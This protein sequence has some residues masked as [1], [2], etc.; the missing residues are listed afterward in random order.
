MEDLTASHWDDVLSPSS[1]PFGTNLALENGFQD[2][3]PLQGDDNSEGHGHE[4]KEQEQEQEEEEEEVDSVGHGYGTEISNTTSKFNNLGFNGVNEAEAAQ[5]SELAKEERKEHTSN[6]IS[7]LT[8]G[9]DIAEAIAPSS[10]APKNASD[11]LFKDST[12]PI[13]IASST[14]TNPLIKDV[15]GNGVGKSKLFARSR[16]FNSKTV[17]SNLSSNKNDVKSI[18]NNNNNNNNNNINSSNPLGPLGGEIT[19]EE[20]ELGKNSRDELFKE[21]ESPLYKIP[22]EEEKKSEDLKPIIPR[23][24]TNSTETVPLSGSS[25]EITVGD[26]MK[27]GDITTAHIVYTIHVKN[28]TPIDNVASSTSGI[29]F[30]GSE[31]VSRRYRDFRWLYHQLQNNHLGIIIPPPPT[32]QTYIGRFNENFIENRRLSLEKMLTKIS[33]LPTICNDPDFI[34]FLTST[35]FINESKERERLSGLEIG[36]DEENTSAD[37]NSSVLLDNELVVSAST[38]GFMNSLFSMSNKVN[39]PNDL[40]KDKK[41]YI[42]NLEF[43][44]RNFYKSLELIGGQRGEIITLV[45]EISLLTEELSSLEILKKTTD[46]LAE[47]SE[48]HLKL[49]DNLDRTNLQDQLTLGFTIEEYLRII[50]SIKS[51]FATRLKIYNKYQTCEQEL[52]KKQ[53]QFDK[54]IKKYKSQHEKINILKFE[55]DKLESRTLKFKNQF[56]LITETIT[57]ELERFEFEKIDDF[58]NSVEI[59][60]ESSIESQKEAIELWETFYERQNLSEI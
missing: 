19:K 54:F 43:N 50:D 45:E 11:S 14:T 7:E 12:S 10:P 33:N 6:L 51:V 27:V 9:S 36:T 35:D 1:N 28:R 52:Y 34:M 13:K 21:V 2:H 26:P 42:E 57:N 4:E 22:K 3:N 18:G 48:I 49:K 59:F 16:R 17:V 23:P 20:T 56:N 31:P 29:D 15:N 58:R 32:K 30:N 25:L 39:E 44:L 53:T 55:V 8:H 60:I 41:T 47:F 46:L 37:M 5:L 38:S 40:I 24:E